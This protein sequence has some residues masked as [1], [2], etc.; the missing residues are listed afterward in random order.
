MILSP[1][2]NHR[3]RM[4]PVGIM[5]LDG[6]IDSEKDAQILYSTSALP[7][8]RYARFSGGYGTAI[9]TAGHYRW[10][11]FDVGNRKIYPTGDIDLEGIVYWRDYCYD[12]GISARTLQ[13]MGFYLLRSTLAGSM[14]ISEGEEMRLWDFPTSA[15][16]YA[17]EGVYE[18]LYQS[19]IRAAYLS[20]LVAMNPARHYVRVPRMTLREVQSHGDGVFVRCSYRVSSKLDAARFAALA[21]NGSVARRWGREK[22][23]SAND[24]R[25]ITALGWDVRISEAWIPGES[26]PR[27]FAEFG[28]IVSEIR[29]DPIMGRTAKLASNTV[30]GSFSAGSNLVHVT[31]PGNGRQ[32][33][34]SVLPPR[35]KLCQPLAFSVIAHLRERVMIEG[36]GD[37]TVQAHTDGIISPYPLDTGK[38]IGQWRTVGRF[39]RVDVVRPSCYAVTVNGETTYKVAGRS[40]SDDISRRMFRER[41]MRYGRD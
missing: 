35:S 14:S 4:I 41:L 37:E 22:L 34:T 30:W 16:L 31:F 19:D 15:H 25:L 7:A 2:P 5:N 38:E 6:S 36:M 1:L 18:N 40:G 12:K 27:P 23:L 29:N 24:I 26:Y 21:S 20:A 13:G 11:S 9:R 17:R 3:A 33:K 28:R 8:L 32:P 39:D 10:V